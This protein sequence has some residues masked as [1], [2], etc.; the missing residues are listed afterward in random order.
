MKPPCVRRGW[1]DA[2]LLHAHKGGQSNTG[3]EAKD[4]V[5]PSVL[6]RSR[7]SARNDR[8]RAMAHR[9]EQQAKGNNSNG[10]NA[11]GTATR[12]YFRVP[13]FGGNTQAQGGAH[14]AKQNGTKLCMP[15]LPRPHLSAGGVRA[16]SQHAQWAKG[17]G[18]DERGWG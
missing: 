15:E 13:P 1:P 9:V 10:K 3:G 16:T 18:T 5:M 17:R 4:A 14:R 12:P 7:L 6:P 8:A 11:K 2:L